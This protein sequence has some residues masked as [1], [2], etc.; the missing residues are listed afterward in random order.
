MERE[1][2]AR[3]LD[4]AAEICVTKHCE[5]RDKMGHAYFMHPM[6]VALRCA[7]DEQK[8]V[9]MLHDVIEDCGVTADDLREA[10]FPAEVI[11]GVLAVT[12]LAD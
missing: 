5:Q 9:A 10:G 8:M 7:T 1:E 2:A 6:R 4:I 12:R 11:E 3:L